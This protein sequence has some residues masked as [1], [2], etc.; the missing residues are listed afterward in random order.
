MGDE[1][2]FEFPAVLQMA[3]QIIGDPD[4][5]IL[6]CQ[7]RRFTV[8][9][10]R[11][12][13]S[14]PRVITAYTRDPWAAGMSQHPA[15]RDP[16]PIILEEHPPMLCHGGSIFDTGQPTAWYEGRSCNDK[17]RI[18]IFTSRLLEFRT[19]SQSDSVRDERFRALTL[20][21]WFALVVA[22][23][24]RHWIQDVTDWERAS[25]PRACANWFL[26]RFFRVSEVFVIFFLSLPI[27]CVI[28]PAAWRFVPIDH[29]VETNFCLFIFSLLLAVTAFFKMADAA[30]S[31]EGRV[32]K[33]C[34][35]IDRKYIQLKYKLLPIERDADEFGFSAIKDPEWLGVV[36]IEKA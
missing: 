7:G 30:D 9:L 13:A 26:E 12:R 23:E 14:L 6:K 29:T 25:L 19:P 11:I 5:V 8:H 16:P 20:E 1:D 15:F 33:F 31:R 21:G 4:K 34:S 35:F 17:R 3:P 2:V 36:S 27:F 22:H 18:K 24:L 28:A 10:D 32:Y